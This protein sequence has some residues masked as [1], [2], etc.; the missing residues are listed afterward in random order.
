[1]IKTEGIVL[2][3]MRF[4]DTSK[5]LNVY[6]KDFG[7][8]SVMAKGAYKAKSKLM[9]STQ[10]FSYNEYILGKGHTFYYLNQ[11]TVIHPFYDIREKIER[12]VYGSYILELVE[13][14]S[15]EGEK[16]LTLFLLLKKSLTIL[17]ELDEG[18]L[19]FIVAFQLKFISFIG[20]RPHLNTCI[21]CNRVPKD[22]IKWS[23]EEGGIFCSN[24]ASN[25]KNYAYINR[26]MYRVMVELLYAPLEDLKTI[27]VSLDTL[28][29][30][31]SL[32]EK[33]ILYNIDRD[34]FNSLKTIET[35]L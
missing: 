32:L 26:L 28:K 6:T 17:A 16:N 20:Y 9:A 18:F 22:N 4:K 12:F 8:I 27:D 25:Y 15:P 19:K 1:M 33:Y 10:V 13:K 14:S 34:Q 3:E 5:I 11:G 7:K 30:L 23:N 31:Q 2:S 24:C 21:G 35:L 29:S